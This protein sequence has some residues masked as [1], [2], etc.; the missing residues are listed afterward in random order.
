MILKVDD[1][2]SKELE[3]IKECEG[4]GNRTSTFVFLVKYYF[5]TRKDS[6]DESIEKLNELLDKKVSGKKLPRAKEQLRDL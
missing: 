2:I 1:K 6:L 4:L 3:M 5:L